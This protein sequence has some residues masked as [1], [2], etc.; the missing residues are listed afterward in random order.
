MA[1][2]AQA[3]K[4]IRQNEKCRV[5]NKSVKS[6]IKT[7]TKKLSMLLENDQKDDAVQL[8]PQLMSK[9]DKAAKRNVFHKNTVARKK[10]QVARLVGGAK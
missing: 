1:H 7:L 8:L 6:E 2:S 3:K 9:L 5:R 4:R 10:S